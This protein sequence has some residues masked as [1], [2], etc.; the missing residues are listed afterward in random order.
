[1]GLRQGTTVISP[2]RIQDDT[3]P[4]PVAYANE[5]NGGTQS[6]ATLALRDA[7]PTFLRNWGMFFV[8]YN[9]GNN[10][11]TYQLVYGLV[12]TN[13]ANNAN[14]K[15]FQSSTGTSSGGIVTLN[16]SI[17]GSNSI[18]TPN[19]LYMLLATLINAQTSMTNVSIGYSATSDELMMAQA[20][21]AGYFPLIKGIIFPQ[22][23][24]IWFNNITAQS[25][26]SLILLTL[27]S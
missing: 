15:L 2:V 26:C 18:T 6:G 10:D 7:T 8:V 22:A 25:T 3:I 5:I 13:L 20:I 11:G 24:T 17:L 9:D 27:Q 4:N 19:G 12:D 1:M 21:G 14:W 16:Q 23:T